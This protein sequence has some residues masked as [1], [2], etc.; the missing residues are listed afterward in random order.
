MFLERYPLQ[1]DE[2]VFVD[3]TEENVKAAKAIGFMGIEFRGP[4]ELMLALK[5]LGI[6]VSESEDS[7]V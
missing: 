1:A 6:H 4:E 5:G 3:D 7:Y 2:C